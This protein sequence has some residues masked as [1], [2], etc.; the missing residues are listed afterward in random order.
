MSGVDPAKLAD[1]FRARFPGLVLFA[2]QWLDGAEA[3]DVVQE[4]FVRLLALGDE[5]ANVKAWLYL[6]TRRAAI[7][8]ARSGR[9]RQRR[10]RAAAERHREAAWFQPGPADRIDA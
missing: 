9:R 2:R 7:A 10:E 6:A 4:V 3:E 8:A 1:W 5:P